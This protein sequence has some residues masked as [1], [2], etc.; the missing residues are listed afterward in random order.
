M[1]QHFEQAPRVDRPPATLCIAT[2][3]YL[4]ATQGQ[5][6]MDKRPGVIHNKN[7]ADPRLCG[8]NGHRAKPNRTP[9]TALSSDGLSNDLHAKHSI[10]HL[11]DSQGRLLLAANIVRFTQYCGA[12]SSC[13]HYKRC[14]KRD[15]LLLRRRKLRR[16]WN[17]QGTEH[18]VERKRLTYAYLRRLL[19]TSSRKIWVLLQGN[20]SNQPAI[21]P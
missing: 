12:K 21:D 11:Q 17:C 6:W 9:L 14:R 20:V 1:R 13:Q 16:N 8:C 18:R 4:P 3:S 15:P 5:R 7:Y 2:A 19:D 10:L